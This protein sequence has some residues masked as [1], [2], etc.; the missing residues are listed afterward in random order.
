MASGFDWWRA[1]GGGVLEGETDWCSPRPADLVQDN[2]QRTLTTR[3]QWGWD[4]GGY[5]M[6]RQLVFS[7]WPIK[8]ISPD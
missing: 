5:S 6:G 1:G 8:H 4:G 7:S 2:E 3:K